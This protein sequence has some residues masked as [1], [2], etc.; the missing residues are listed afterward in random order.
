[1]R[2]ARRTQSSPAP[3]TRNFRDCSYDEY[4]EFLA[5]LA[6]TPE[7]RRMRQR[8][9]REFIDH[10]PKLGDWL[11]EPLHERVGRLCAETQQLPSYPVSYRAR[12]Y[13]FYLALTDRVLLDYDWLFAIGDLAIGPVAGPL[14]IHFGVPK[15]AAEGARHGY[16]PSSV[17]ASMRWAL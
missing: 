12:S 1:M 14:G 5:S 8:Y 9:R 17:A 2:A 6:V 4:A 13:L 11:V 3:S 10:W 15:L 7:F 16:R